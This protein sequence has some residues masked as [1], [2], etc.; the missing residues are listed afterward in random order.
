LKHGAHLYEESIRVP[1]VIAGPWPRRAA[2][3]RRR[4]SMSPDG[5]SASRL[6]PQA[7]SQRARRPL[8]HCT[9]LRFRLALRLRG[10]LRRPTAA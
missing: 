1:L 3:P 4:G 8:R 7:R 5:R 10:L 9:G 6:R 2:T